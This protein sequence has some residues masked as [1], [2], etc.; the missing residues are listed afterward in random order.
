MP[1]HST[2]ATKQEDGN[3]T[4]EDF[5]WNNNGDIIRK[6]GPDKKYIT[7]KNDK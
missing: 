3:E 5:V 6:I 4:S 2:L 1:Y 7:F